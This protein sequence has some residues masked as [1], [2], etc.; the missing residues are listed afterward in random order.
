MM[1]PRKKSSRI[2]TPDRRIIRPRRGLSLPQESILV[3]TGKLRFIMSEPGGKVGLYGLRDVKT[4]LYERKE[5][6][7]R[8]VQVEMPIQTCVAVLAVKEARPSGQ[9]GEVRGIFAHIALPKIKGLSE[10]IKLQ[11]GLGSYVDVALDVIERQFYDQR[12]S[13]KNLHLFAVP[14]NASDPIT[15]GILDGIRKHADEK[16]WDL[17]E[18]FITKDLQGK[19][20]LHIVSLD[21]KGHYGFV[22]DPGIH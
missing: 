13:G 2:I 6:I 5:S 7:S 8:M 12:V 18:P 1:E 21:N 15:R 10:A 3:P 16:K 19:H 11:K 20:T 17:T 14:G 22:A 9:P 4:N